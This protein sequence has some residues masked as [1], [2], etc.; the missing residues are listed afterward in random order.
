VTPIDPGSLLLMGAGVV[1]VLLA[2]ML[3]GAWLGTLEQPEKDDPEL[4]AALRL[5]PEQRESALHRWLWYI[6][7]RRR[8]P[9]PPP[10]APPRP[11]AS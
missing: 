4:K 3:L 1:A 9:P 7:P 8:P 11:P 2:F 5:P 6:G 10:P